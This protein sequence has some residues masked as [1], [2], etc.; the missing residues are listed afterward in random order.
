MKTFFSPWLFWMMRTASD[1][2]WVETQ[3]LA[4]PHKT[5]SH[6]HCRL[7]NPPSPLWWTCLSTN[8]LVVPV[9]LHF[10]SKLHI[11][12]IWI[13]THPDNLLSSLPVH[14]KILYWTSSRERGHQT[15]VINVT[16]LFRRL[17][18]PSISTGEPDIQISKYIFGHNPRQSLKSK[19]NLR[20]KL[21]ILHSI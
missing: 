7:W 16:K 1:L 17:I 13:S 10:N 9:H 20:S 6:W 5:D 12:C 2:Q 14:I 18:P 8:T 11:F 21:L 15:P 3:K 4:W 19:S